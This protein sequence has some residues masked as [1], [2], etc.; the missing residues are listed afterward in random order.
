M[1]GK[2]GSTRRERI[3]GGRV[4]PLFPSRG[5]IDV[6]LVGEAPGPRGA[7]RSGIPFWGDR[8][9]R[10]LYRALAQAGMAE[11]PEDAWSRWEGAELAGLRLLP[12]LQR[13]ALSNALPYCQTRD[14]RSFCAPSR[15]ELLANQNRAR[16]RD[17]IARAA[18]RCRGRLLVIALGRKSESLLAAIRED[19]PPFALEYLPHPSAQALAAGRAGASMRDREQDW[20]ARLVALLSPTTRARGA[21]ARDSRAPRCA[22]DRSRL[23]RGRSRSS[24]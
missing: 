10:L 13:A 19:A 15:A 24:S 7:D 8:S 14:G 21:E 12:R 6:L 18:R 3:R 9:G 1:P 23:C 2:P 20:Q 16:M 5:P 17:E 4:P 11:V 22:T